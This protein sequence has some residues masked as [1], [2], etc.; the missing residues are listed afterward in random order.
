ML[1]KSST[2]HAG[3]VSSTTSTSRVGRE[4]SDR[5]YETESFFS[6]LGEGK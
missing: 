2:A 1:S 6:Q 3:D 4:T 5:I